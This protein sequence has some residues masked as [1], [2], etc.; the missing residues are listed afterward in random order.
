[1]GFD[2]QKSAVLAAHFIDAE[3]RGKLGHGFSRVEW[4]ATQDIDPAA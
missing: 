4:L 2:E 3:E 1:M